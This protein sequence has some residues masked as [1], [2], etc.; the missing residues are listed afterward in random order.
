MNRYEIL[1]STHVV[2]TLYREL[3]VENRSLVHA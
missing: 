3:R 1:R 2:N